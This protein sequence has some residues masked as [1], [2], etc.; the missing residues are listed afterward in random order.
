MVLPAVGRGGEGEGMGRGGEGDRRGGSVVESKKTK[1]GVVCICLH[2]PVTART[3]NVYS[4]N[5]L[6]RCLNSECLLWRFHCT[7]VC[8][9]VYMCM[10]TYV[11]M[12]HA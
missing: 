3:S 8:A 6:E 12:C 9:C 2:I 5:L 4:V 10:C 11:C 1:T 7:C